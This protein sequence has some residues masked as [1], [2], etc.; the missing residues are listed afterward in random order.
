MHKHA[1]TAK[2]LPQRVRNRRKSPNLAVDQQRKTAIV[3]PA[4]G[5]LLRPL[6]RNW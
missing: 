6:W 5:D 3:R 4:S 1:V 2:S